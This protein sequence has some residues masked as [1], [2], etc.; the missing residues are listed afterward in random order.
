MV[1]SHDYGQAYHGRSRGYANSKDGKN[2][3]GEI[4]RGRKFSKGHKINVYGI[5]HNLQ[6]QQN[7]Y[8]AAAGKDPVKSDR[9]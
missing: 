5:E 3:P 8:R 9:K 4:M 2:L 7:P 6:R 1:D